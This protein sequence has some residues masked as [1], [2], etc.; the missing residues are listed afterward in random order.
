[1]TG[2]DRGDG[3]SPHTAPHLRSVSMQNA[4]RNR[5][6]G[7]PCS[8]LV[9][10]ALDMHA[11]LLDT[12]KISLRAGGIT[13]QACGR[14]IEATELD[15]AYQRWHVASSNTCNVLSL[16]LRRTLSA[17]KLLVQASAG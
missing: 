17:P 16:V 6:A 2:P 8:P 1:M 11:T 13:W 3:P 10:F 14:A 12:S 4:R 7:L 15:R 5:T 9:H